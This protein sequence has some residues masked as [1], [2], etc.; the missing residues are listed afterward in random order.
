ML[1]N[2]IQL[3]S[4]EKI[5]SSEYH[6]YSNEVG[7]NKENTKKYA[8]PQNRHKYCS[9]SIPPRTQTNKNMCISNSALRVCHIESDIGKNVDKYDTR[10]LPCNE[11]SH[12][13]IHPH[14]KIN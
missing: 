10:L 2:L 6:T 13:T 12:A 3:D 8:Y 5:V 9:K 14:P 7:K 1:S 4:S 11:T